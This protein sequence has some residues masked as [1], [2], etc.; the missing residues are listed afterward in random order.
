MFKNKALIPIF[1][2]VFVDLLG[3]S[4]VLPLL[5]F[6]AQDFQASPETIGIFVA[7]YSVFQ[8]I[9]SPILGGL[10]DRYGRRPMLIYSQIGSMIGFILLGIGG[11]LAILFISRIIDGISGG[12][13]TIAQAYISDVTEPKDRASS[14]AVIGIAFGLGF[15]L[16]PFI[17]GELTSLFNRNAPAY[18]AAGFSALSILLTIFYLKEPKVHR[19]VPGAKT[20]LSYYVRMLDY[21]KFKTLRTFLFIFLF[22]AT[23]FTLYVSM[24]SLYANIQLA[25]TEA[26]VGRFLAFVGLLGIIWQGGAIRPLVKKFGELKLLRIGMIF[27]A[28]GLFAIVFATNWLELAIVAVIF[29][30]GSSVTRPVIS[31][32]VT[33]AAP[34]D[35]K[36]SVLGIASSIESFTRIIAPIAGGRIIGGLHPNYIGYVGAALAAVGVLLAFR[37]SF[38]RHEV[39]GEI[40]VD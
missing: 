2:V 1:V 20:G 10:S 33:Q 18:C 25:F 34:Q 32:L 23:P 30:F 4:I 12:N 36:G 17:G 39:T 7:S 22:F 8:F 40:I 37:V 5:P 28:V 21:F 24:F 26:E 29:S 35:K 15:M 13:L 16:G 11:S 38:D 9:S 31:S 27:L 14:F 19:S 3:F 6:Y